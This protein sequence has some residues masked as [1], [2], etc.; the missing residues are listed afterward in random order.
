MKTLYQLLTAGLVTATLLVGCAPSQT[1]KELTL[2]DA[3]GDKFLI[4]TAVNS[5][6]AAGKDTV[7]AKLI[8]QQFN[9]IVAENCM[10]S[11]VI[12][13]EENRYDFTLA[14]QFVDFG[15]K[16]NLVV[17][18][19]TL[20]WHSQLAP[21]FCVDEKGQNVSPEVLKTRMKEHI[22]TIVSRYKGRIKGWDVVNEAIEDDGSYRQTKFYEILGEE[23]IPLA[24]QYAREAD[25]AAE[26]YYNDF[27]MAHPG[28]RDAV[29]KLV[30][31]LK[32]RGLRIDAVGMQGHMTM[33]FPEVSAFEESMLAFASTGA[34][35]MI[36][37]LDMTLLPS[38][39]P[40]IGANVSASFEY[41]K[42]M[43]PY[44]DALPDSVAQAWNA[45][46]GEF[47]NLFLKHK[48]IITRVTLWGAADSDSWRN[49]WPIKGRTDYAL[50]FDRNHQSKPVVETIIQ[51]ATTVT[52]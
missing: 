4:G 25:P 10:K 23:Y 27:S 34:K 7:G 33:N 29:V 45:R 47:F 2:K 31:Q 48:D 39:K 20:I 6:Q 11:E 37:E 36:T 44:P 46:M 16:N 5:N 8:L 42:E 52:Q 28:K 14:D 49:D 12:H 21:W 30:K 26:L 22:T 50:L 24:F 32:E 43:N 38:P 35:V 19:H 9:A 1:K 3:L 13:P 17:T 40:N 18:G 15:T 41:K 51:E